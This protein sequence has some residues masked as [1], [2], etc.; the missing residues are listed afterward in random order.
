[1]LEMHPSPPPRP[2]PL[3]CCSGADAIL[4][5]ALLPPCCSGADAIL[6]IAAVL[7]NQDLAYFMKAATSLGMQV[8]GGVGGGGLYSH[9]MQVPYCSRTKAPLI[10]RGRGLAQHS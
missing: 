9:A 1:M 4:P 5:P 3:P 10:L 8:C 7:P 2:H 6:L